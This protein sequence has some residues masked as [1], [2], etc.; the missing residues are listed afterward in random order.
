MYESNTVGSVK[1]W[2]SVLTGV[3]VEQANLRES[4]EAIRR[5]RMKTVRDNRVFHPPRNH[6][7][8]QSEFA[9]MGEGGGGVEGVMEFL[10]ELTLEWTSE[11]ELYH[12]TNM[13]IRWKMSVLIYNLERLRHESDITTKMGGRQP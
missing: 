12:L 9:R 7:K 6:L 1:E 4:I 13:K 11:W 3:H 5:D 2:L 8:E 10:E